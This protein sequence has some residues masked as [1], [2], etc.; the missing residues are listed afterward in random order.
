MNIEIKNR[1]NNI[2]EISLPNK[3]S[4][5]RLQKND[6]D[7]YCAVTTFVDPGH[8]GKGIGSILYDEMIKFI[9]GNKTKFRA[10]CPFIVDRANQD[11]KNKDIYLG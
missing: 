1:S 5:V 11:K 4:Y 7:T 9:K 3:N 10:T 2:I 6:D 8:R